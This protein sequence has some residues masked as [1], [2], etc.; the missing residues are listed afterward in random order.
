MIWW[1]RLRV[2]LGREREEEPRESAGSK[3]IDE[4]LT[5]SSIE[6]SRSQGCYFDYLTPNI[7]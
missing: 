6:K 3:Y 5:K 4:P 7:Y 2:H 1:M